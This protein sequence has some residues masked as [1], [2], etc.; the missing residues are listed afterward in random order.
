MKTNRSEK[1]QAFVLIIVAIVAIFG[2]AAL[3]VDGGNV[4]AERR[5]AQ[6]AADASAS[7]GSF[8][9]AARKSNWTTGSHEPGRDQRV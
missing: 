3:A 1:G 7:G 4:Y 5:R 6:N 8:G 9:Q 2:F